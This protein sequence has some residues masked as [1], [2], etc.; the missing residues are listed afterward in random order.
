[1]PALVIFPGSTFKGSLRLAVNIQRAPG[2]TCK[3]RAGAYCSSCSSRRGEQKMRAAA[4]FSY[5]IACILRA[6]TAVTA[7]RQ[8]AACFRFA[9]R[10][11]RESRRLLR[12]SFKLKSNAPARCGSVRARNAGRR[13]VG[14]E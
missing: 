6:S 8:A 12:A 3:Q 9:A 10:G 7:E 4:L 2:P 1:M 11:T 5:F 13:E 14:G